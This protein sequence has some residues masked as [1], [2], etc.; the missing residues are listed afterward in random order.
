MEVQTEEGAGDART[1]IGSVVSL[2]R[3]PVKSMIGEELNASYITKGGLLGDRVYALEDETTGRVV[4]AKNPRK[5]GKLF[6]CRASFVQDP[7]PDRTLPPVR[8]ILPCG[9]SVVSDQPDADLKLSDALAARVKL[10]G[11][12]PE[13][14]RYE[15]YWPD[16][17]GRPHRNEITEEL[18]P[19]RTFFDGAPIHILTTATLDALRAFY[20]EGRIEARRFRPNIVIAP[21]AM[22]RGF[23][24][25][26]WLQRTLQIGDEVVLKMTAPCSR[27]IMTTLPQ[28]DLPEDLGVLR[29]AGRYNRVHVGA[30]A[31]VVR[32]GRIRRGDSVMLRGD[33]I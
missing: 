23:V 15:E 16:M 29:A 1:S 14:S 11:S 33:T 30:Y 12:A 31:S 18:M 2:W 4:S 28:G 19:P 27:C 10:L 24:E 20:P 5:W 13:E 6:D 7:L 17:E 25:N 9:D 3:Y 8:V 21:S 26:D 22:E 32:E